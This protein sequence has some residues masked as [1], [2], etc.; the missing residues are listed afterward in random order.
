MED[1]LAVDSRVSSNQGLSQTERIIDT[2]VAPSKT[3]MDILRSTSWWLPFLLILVVSAASAFVMDRKIGFEHIA[4]HAMQQT[5][6]A[7]EQMAQLTPQQRE[8]Q[9]SIAA[10]FTKD[11]SY[12]GGVF[13]LGIAALVALLMWASFNFGLGANTTFSQNLA[14]FFYAYLPHVFLA[15]L[16]IIFVYAGVNT[17]NFDINNPVGTNVEY[18]MTD[19]AQWLKTMFGYFDVFG[20]WT[21]ALLVVGSAIITR[22][23]KG[24]VA[25]VVVGWWVIM[26]L[27]TTAAAAA[28]G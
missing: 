20:L 15:V 4:E 28:R 23:S 6:K 9:I 16:N 1:V 2:F 26:V 10:V 8:T 7:A 5:P 21:L 22:K 11:I 14:V 13:F 3:F 12:A 27:V 24:Q 18:Y 19:S 25:I 17:E